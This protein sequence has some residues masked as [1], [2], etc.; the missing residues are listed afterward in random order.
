MDAW[1]EQLTALLTAAGGDG[2]RRQHGGSVPPESGAIA[3][4]AAVNGVAATWL[5]C[6]DLFSPAHQAEALAQAILHGILPAREVPCAASGRG[7][8]EGDARN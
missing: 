5:A 4:I 6:P 2:H 8:V 7:D 3:I 1:A